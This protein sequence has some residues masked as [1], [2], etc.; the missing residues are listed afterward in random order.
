MYTV[1]RKP[2]LP[3]KGIAISLPSGKCACLDPRS[4]SSIP[5]S[6]PLPSPTPAF[7]F[8][9][10]ASLPPP[11]LLTWTV[12]YGVNAGQRRRRLV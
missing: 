11:P 8:P 4:S 5:F 10:A 7:P 12:D 6:P 9:Y 2:R 3:A 1:D